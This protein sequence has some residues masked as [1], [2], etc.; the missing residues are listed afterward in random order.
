MIRLTSL[1]A[2]IHQRDGKG[3]WSLA[4]EILHREY[5]VGGGSSTGTEELAQNVAAVTYG[6]Q[7]LPRRWNHELA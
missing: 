5:Q 1:T 3:T 6:G 7:L 4:S 2:F